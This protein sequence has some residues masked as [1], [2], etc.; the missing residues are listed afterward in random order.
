MIARGAVVRQKRGDRIADEYLFYDLLDLHLTVPFTLPVV[1]QDITL[2]VGKQVVN[3]GESTA[4]VI[5]SLTQAN[6]VNANNIFRLGNALLEDLFVPVNMANIS[7]YLGGGVSLQAHYVFNWQP[8]EIPPPGSFFSFIDAGT[9]NLGS[10]RL[11]AS[12]GQ[13][14]DDLNLSLIHI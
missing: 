5:N 14:P 3:W 11:N 4:A 13:A 1:D 7:T 9:D 6:P 2:R 10:D 12:F 8:V